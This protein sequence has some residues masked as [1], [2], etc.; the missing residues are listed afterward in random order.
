VKLA[1]VKENIDDA[2]VCCWRNCY[3]CCF[4]TLLLFC[5]DWETSETMWGR[6]VPTWG[7]LS[8]KHESQLLKILL[9]AELKTK[10]KFVWHFWHKRPN[11]CQ[12][13]VVVF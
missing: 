7:R 5:N 3:T 13:T 8:G 11:H 12:S 4:A 1:R 6:G 10:K 9:F 2:A